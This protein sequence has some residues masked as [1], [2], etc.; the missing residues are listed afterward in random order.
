[1]DKITVLVSEEYGY[2]WWVWDTGMTES[3]LIKFWENIPEMRKHYMNPSVTL[4]GKWHEASPGH[5]RWFAHIHWEDDSFLQKTLSDK[6][7]YHKG[8]E[9]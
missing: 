7:Y 4:P 9:K 8:L 1:M 6:K 2:R 3:E 5:G